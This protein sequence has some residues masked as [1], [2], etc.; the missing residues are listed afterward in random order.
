MS[1]SAPELLEKAKHVGI[2]TAARHANEVDVAARFPHEAV[3][4]LKKHRLLGAGVPPEFGGLGAGMEQLAAACETLGQYC[5]ST[6]MIYA[7]HL[8]QVACIV[9][10]RAASP[11]F[12]R[13]LVEV[14]E[15]QTLI[16]SVTS[17]ATVGGD[18]IAPR[19][20]TRVH[21][22]GVQAVRVIH[23]SPL[24]RVVACEIVPGEWIRPATIRP[25]NHL[26]R[27]K[28]TRTAHPSMRGKRI[29]PWLGPVATGPQLP[30]TGYSGG[31]Q[32]RPFENRLDPVFHR[33]HLRLVP[34][35]SEEPAQVRLRN[36]QRRG[37]DQWMCLHPLRP[38]HILVDQ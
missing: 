29:R 2:E 26:S 32:R 11:F 21:P 31:G 25:T 1:P 23:R 35:D 34:S 27:D 36:H 37:V 14:A 5:A 13:Y 8:I 18:E 38:P 17:E 16:A 3:D 7:M 12:A 10:H 20:V 33:D 22:I 9:R 15:K 4:A 24:A 6:A 28:F 19:D 30:P